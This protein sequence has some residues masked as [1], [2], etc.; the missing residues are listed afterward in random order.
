MTFYVEE[1]VCDCGAPMDPFADACEGCLA[2]DAAFEA[3]DLQRKLEMEDYDR[4][5]E[6]SG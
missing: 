1:P 6:S 5:G 4:M 3:F 2:N